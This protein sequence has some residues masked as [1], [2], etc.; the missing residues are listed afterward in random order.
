[1]PKYIAVEGD[2]ALELPPSF[3][4]H[5]RGKS[6]VPRGLETLHDVLE[7]KRLDENKV[8]LPIFVELVG[9]LVF[10]NSPLRIYLLIKV[11]RVFPL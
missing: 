10:L 4:A 8:G 11:D 6:F 1:L 7:A 3:V 5:K 2:G 9:C